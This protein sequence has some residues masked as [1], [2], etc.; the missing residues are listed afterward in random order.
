MPGFFKQLDESRN[1]KCLICFQLTKAKDLSGN[2]TTGGLNRHHESHQRW[3][4]VH[5][6]RLDMDNYF[7][8]HPLCYRQ[9]TASGQGIIVFAH[10]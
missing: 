5:E 7:R 6:R 2:M 4:I 3:K 10:L 1:P 9:W 8:F